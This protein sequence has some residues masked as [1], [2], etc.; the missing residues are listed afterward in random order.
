MAVEYNF[1]QRRIDP[2]HIMTTYYYIILMDFDEQ[3]CAH[4]HTI[5]LHI[6]QYIF[7]QIYVQGF[8]LR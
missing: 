6:Y 8:V 2:C 7:V 1:E 5:E 3:S 4:T